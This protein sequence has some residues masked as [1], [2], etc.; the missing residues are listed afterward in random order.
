MVD[1]IKMEYWKKDA[2]GGMTQEEEEEFSGIKNMEEAREFMKNC[3]D[4][5]R[6]DEWKAVMSSG[7]GMSGAFPKYYLEKK[8]GTLIRK[9]NEIE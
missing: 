7:I 1:I 8:D 3:Y 2:P 5:N 9:E 6:S 4:K